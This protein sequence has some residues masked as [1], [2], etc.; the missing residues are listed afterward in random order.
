[1]TPC[2]IFSSMNECVRVWFLEVENVRSNIAHIRSFVI[3]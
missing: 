2:I 1:M 3:Y